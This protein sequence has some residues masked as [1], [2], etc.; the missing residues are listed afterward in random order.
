M[1]LCH[2]NLSRN[3]LFNGGKTIK[4]ESHLPQRRNCLMVTLSGDEAESKKNK[5]QES[6]LVYLPYL[7][8]VHL[9]FG[10]RNQIH[11]LVHSQLLFYRLAISEALVLCPLNTLSV[12]H[13]HFL[14]TLIIIIVIYLYSL[15]I[16]N[17]INITINS[18]FLLYYY[19]NYYYL[20][21]CLRLYRQQCINVV[22]PE[23]R[24][25]RQIPWS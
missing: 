21:I 2:L 4:G 25:G 15:N 24:G 20:G 16:N 11:N 6:H 19:S 14:G 10:I 12:P 22:P 9:L 8:L 23:A 17:I 7:F 1:P 13:Q 3:C 18:Y 5:K